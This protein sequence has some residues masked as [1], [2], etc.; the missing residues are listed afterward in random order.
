MY[1]TKFL[2][3]QYSLGLKIDDIIVYLILYFGTKYKFLNSEII[4]MVDK[5]MYNMFVDNLIKNPVI[6]KLFEEKLFSKKDTFI[7]ISIDYL[8]EKFP[9][10]LIKKPENIKTNDRLVKWI[11]SQID[12]KDNA[13]ILDGNVKINGFYH[14]FPN[15][16][17]IYGICDNENIKKL[18]EINYKIKN[19]TN[20]KKLYISNILTTNDI[21]NK[22]FF[23]F[24]FIEF[25]SNLVNITHAS[26]CD[27][28][29]QLKIRGTKAEPLLT[30]WVLQS[31][32]IN[33]TAIIIVPDFLLFNDSLQIVKTRE[34]MLD[35]YYIKYIISINDII[36][37]K[38][39]ICLQR[40]AIL[41]K[42]NNISFKKLSNDMILQD[43]FDIDRNIIEKN[44]FSLYYKIYETLNIIS[45]T[46]N[47]INQANNIVTVQD[48]F[49]IVKADEFDMKFNKIICL[50]KYIQNNIEIVEDENYFKENKDKWEYVIISK[51][52]DNFD[53]L[54]LKDILKNNI[55]K[56]TKGIMNAIIIDNIKSLIFPLYSEKT[57]LF[58]KE[59]IEYNDTHMKINKEKKEQIYKLKK[60]FFDMI[61][62]YDFENIELSKIIEL[63][64]DV[65]YNKECISMLKNTINV[66][67]V[68]FYDNINELNPH[69]F[70]FKPKKDCSINIKYIYHW[71]KMTSIVKDLSKL[72]HNTI[73]FNKLLTLKIPIVDN[74]YHNK[75]IEQFENFDKELEKLNEASILYEKF[76]IVDVILL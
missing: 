34:Y 31:L 35:N 2:A 38:S 62:E 33:G 7:D 36:E 22:L 32:E 64:G 6:E 10:K 5:K 12:F 28:I 4:D 54:I 48:I 60:I 61:L 18:L 37:N 75:I 17:N 25:P 14:N 50:T 27:K 21:D 13:N 16:Y 41:N 43:L 46:N 42:S 76:N 53:I 45:N 23:D 20:M 44:N 71:L 11:T 39:I 73:T 72:S 30:Q 40:P 74:K 15:N 68:F 24:I 65:K 3:S 70:Y 52:N 56:Y 47:T 55:N 49:N 26:C 9:Q 59:L 67:D 69:S 57:K 1:I 66:A 29:K 8:I 58:A 63:I 19:E 51:T